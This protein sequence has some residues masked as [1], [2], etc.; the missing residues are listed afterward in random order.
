MRGDMVSELGL[1]AL[2]ANQV[3]RAI[4]RMDDKVSKKKFFYAIRSTYNT[5]AIDWSIAIDVLGTPELEHILMKWSF[6]GPH[7]MTTSNI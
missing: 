1:A 6:L 2:Y 3:A 7:G 5:F 4:V